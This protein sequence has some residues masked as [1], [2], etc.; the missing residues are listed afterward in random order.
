MKKKK[1]RPSKSKRRFP[2]KRSAFGERFYHARRSRGLTRDDLAKEVGL[3]T[4]TI[5]RYETTTEPQIK[6]LE[7]LALALNVSVN[8]LLSKSVAE[9]PA[10]ISMTRSFRR[11]IDILKNLAEKDKQQVLDLIDFLDAKPKR[12]KKPRPYRSA[13]VVA[14]YP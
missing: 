6:T 8:H 7:K 11:S 4:R 3:S 1:T 5:Y 12:K 14:R 9:L 2:L 13:A 10:D